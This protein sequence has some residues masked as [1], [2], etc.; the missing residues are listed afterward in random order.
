M[1]KKIIFLL[2]QIQIDVNTVLEIITGRNLAQA[3]GAAA[4]EVSAKSAKL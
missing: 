4:P 1:L 2:P 3:R